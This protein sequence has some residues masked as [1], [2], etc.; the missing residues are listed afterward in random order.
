MGDL[1]L[2]G[3]FE[4]GSSVFLYLG[5]C[6]F[7]SMVKVDFKGVFLVFCGCYGCEFSIFCLGV[8][9]IWKE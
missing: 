2:G 6:C 3:C 9:F 1:S 5:V 4:E 8:P 7:L